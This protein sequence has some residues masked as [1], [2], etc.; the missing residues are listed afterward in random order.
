MPRAGLI[1]RRLC[2]AADRIGQH[3]QNNVKAELDPGILQLVAPPAPTAGQLLPF[4]KPLLR[5]NNP[6]HHETLSAGAAFD[7]VSH[8]LAQLVYC[9]LKV[10]LQSGDRLPKPRRIPLRSLFANLLKDEAGVTAIEYALIAALIAV[11]AIGAFTL[12][13]TSLSNTFTLIANTS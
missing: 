8:R 9:Y 10:R 1:S 5:G 4:E 7:E 12:V 6:F 3:L 11:A 13:G 2:C